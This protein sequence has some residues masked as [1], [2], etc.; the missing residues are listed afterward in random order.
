L[1]HRPATEFVATFLGTANLLVGQA[2]AD[3]IH[4]GPLRFPL[5]TEAPEMQRQHRVQ[6][7]F[8]PEDVHLAPFSGDLSGPPLGEATVEQAIFGGGFER[9]RLK[10]PPLTGVR[11]IAP[12]TP[13]GVDA[14]LVEA[15]RNQEQA[16]RFPS[17]RATGRGSACAESTR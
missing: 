13:F 17:S 6:V 2:T 14:P 1:Y 16:R 9:L 5:S 7:L 3:G 10:L 15:V 12:A 4:V 11:S 8:R